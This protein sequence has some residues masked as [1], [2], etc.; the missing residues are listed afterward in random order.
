MKGET[1]FWRQATY[2]FTSSN[3]ASAIAV[4]NGGYN[5]ILPTFRLKC[6]PISRSIT[7]WLNLPSVLQ[8]HGDINH[9]S[10]P[11]IRI[12]CTAA[13]YKVPDVWVSA[14]SFPRIL[15]RQYHFFRAFLRF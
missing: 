3:S 13:I 5:F 12:A 15:N 9:S 6:L 10:Y 2:I 4:V 14:P 7:W 1:V 8:M 11:K